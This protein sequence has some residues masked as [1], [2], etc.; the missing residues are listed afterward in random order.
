MSTFVRIPKAAEDPIYGLQV[1]FKKDERP[2]KINLSIGVFPEKEKGEAASPSKAF[3]FS[4]VDRAEERLLQKRLA[5]DYLP[6]DG[7]ASFCKLA[8]DLV[9][10]KEEGQNRPESKLKCYTAQTVGSTAALHIAGRFLAQHLSKKIFISDP[11]WVN[12][13]KLFESAG[14]EVN[15]YPYCI[16]ADGKVDIEAFV[17]AIN[18]MPEGSTIVLQAS[19]HNPTGVDPTDAEWK[20]IS[21]AIFSRKLLPFFD[22]AYQGIGR[23]LDEDAFAIRLFFEEGHEL[24]VATSFAKNLGL[25][26]ERVGALI[27]ACKEED[28]VAVASQIRAVIR[29]IYS[30]PSAHGA[31]VASII[32]SDPELF[33]LWEKE[34]QGL[35]ENL[36]NTRNLLHTALTQ[37]GEQKVLPTLLKSTGLFTMCALS[38][39]KVQALREHQALY[40]CDDGRMNIAA[41]KPNQIESIAQA[42]CEV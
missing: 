40:L 28:E 26:S 9:M 6:I 13:R 15:T 25:Y 5:K 17:Q 35:R 3:R 7:L 32:L 39:E 8:C 23:G 36:A 10:G 11:T 30:S 12:H 42:V 16:T 1:T 37:S 21:R 34:L 24:L 29:S 4:V 19:C 33:S 18:S 31:H 41:I 38:K 27:V 14:L 22:I 20:I 2:Q